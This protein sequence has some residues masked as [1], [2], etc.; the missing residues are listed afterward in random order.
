MAKALD[1]DLKKLKTRAYHRAEWT[2]EV[3]GRYH[4]AILNLAEVDTITM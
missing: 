3:L 4:S 2:E 1:V